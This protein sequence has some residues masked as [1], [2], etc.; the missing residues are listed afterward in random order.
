MWMTCHK[1]AVLYSVMLTHLRRNVAGVS[2]YGRTFKMFM[3]VVHKFTHP[4]K[5]NSECIKNNTHTHTQYTQSPKA[6]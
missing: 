3:K 1:P 5:Q 4:S 6:F 2:D